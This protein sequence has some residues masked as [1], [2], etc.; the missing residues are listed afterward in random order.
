MIKL[1]Q[2]LFKSGNS[3]N[4]YLYLILIA[5]L[6]LILIPF[7]IAAEYKEFESEKFNERITLAINDHKALDFSFQKGKTLEIIYT[8]QINEELPI[9]IWFVN[10]DNYLLLSGGSQFLY[11]LDGTG[12]QVSYAKK[13]VTLTKHDNYKLVMSNYYNNKTVNVNIDGEIRT[14][15]DVSEENSPGFSSILSY[16]LIIIIIILAVLL[17]VISFKLRKSK[18]TEVIETD[19]RSTKKAK[20]GKS[21]KDKY[22]DRDKD[23]QKKARS[24]K[25]KQTK[26][27]DF[28]KITS[29][30]SKVK[31]NSINFCG[32]C[33][34]SIDTPYCKYCGRKV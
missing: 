13:V 20:A 8:V 30:Q 14:F 31:S 25:S 27:K 2:Y 28:N 15:N 34:K 4:I 16:I 7:N 22:K 11:F 9:D 21:K 19:K 23:S 6:L 18:Q 10:E 17:I 26:G 24:K 32:F 12:Q 3:L 5:I 1:K 29:K 33:G